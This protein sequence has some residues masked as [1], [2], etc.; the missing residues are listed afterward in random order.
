MEIKG[1]CASE[2]SDER[3]DSMC[4]RLLTQHKHSNVVILGLD[5]DRKEKNNN[6]VSVWVCD[7]GA[8]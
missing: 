4:L 6:S 7:E 2:S 3:Q 8:L 5:H 1:L